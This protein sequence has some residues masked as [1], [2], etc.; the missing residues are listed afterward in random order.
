MQNIK[1]IEKI[2]RGGVLRNMPIITVIAAVAVYGILSKEEMCPRCRYS[3]SVR[4]KSI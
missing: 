1:T 2:N 3:K 4:C